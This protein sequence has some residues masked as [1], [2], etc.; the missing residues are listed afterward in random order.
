MLGTRHRAPGT[1]HGRL[2]L[3]QVP[4][5]AL[6]RLIVHT[7]KTTR[8][9]IPGGRA[10][11]QLHQVWTL[12]S[13][14]LRSRGNSDTMLDQ[15]PAPPLLEEQGRRQRDR[16]AQGGTA[17][18]LCG[19]GGKSICAPW[20]AH[21]AASEWNCVFTAK[22]RMLSRSRLGQT[23]ARIRSRGIRSGASRARRVA[24]KKLSW[25]RQRPSG[26]RWPIPL[27]EWTPWRRFM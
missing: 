22:A 2:C 9:T 5:Q 17:Q 10:V 27:G 4:Q 23:S 6:R 19:A 13:Q 18:G 21:G 3:Q 8:P 24:K 26:Q 1:S 25:W 16:R 15:L 7:S 14:L 12:E 11:L 20:T